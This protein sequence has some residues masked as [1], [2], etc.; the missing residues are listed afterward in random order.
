LNNL[1][2]QVH[3]IFSQV[4]EAGFKETLT[5]DQGKLSWSILACETTTHGVAIN[6]HTL[7]QHHTEFG[8]F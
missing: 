6:C 5:T 4:F 7:A 8:H 3:N 1:T 2:L